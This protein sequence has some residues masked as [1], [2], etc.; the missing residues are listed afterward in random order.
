[1]QRDKAMTAFAIFH[2]RLFLNT[3]RI[4]NGESVIVA[5]VLDTVFTNSG[6]SSH[7]SFG[8]DFGIVIRIEP[9][10]SADLAIDYRAARRVSQ[11]LRIHAW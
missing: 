9:I 7:E 5:K 3:K 10:L 4:V 2:A 1:M 8:H 11:R 6:P